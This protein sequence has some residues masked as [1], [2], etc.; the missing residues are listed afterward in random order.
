ML[1]AIS[2]VVVKMRPCHLRRC[3]KQPPR[4]NRQHLQRFH[5]GRL[6]LRQQPHRSHRIH[7]KPMTRRN[8][9]RLGRVSRPRA[10][11][12]HRLRAR[13]SQL[14]P[15][16]SLRLVKLA[17]GLKR[18]ASPETD[19]ALVAE[20]VET[21]AVELAVHKLSFVLRSRRNGCWLPGVCDKRGF[22]P[23]QAPQPTRRGESPVIIFTRR[24]P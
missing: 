17:Q 10:R 15:A 20:Q 7:R 14:G 2:I 12:G 23:R 6:H 3:L 18:P 13:H 19:Q 1:S 9:I 8:V 4:R 11:L 24:S 22:R 5:N 21:T 16:Y